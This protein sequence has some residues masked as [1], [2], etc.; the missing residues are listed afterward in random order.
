MG[1]VILLGP[2][3]L[4]SSVASVTSVGEEV[5]R[6]IFTWSDSPLGSLGP[7]LLLMLDAETWPSLAKEH[8]EAIVPT[9]SCRY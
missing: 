6:S 8:Q 2:L 1:T 5:W 4:G 9:F 3:L 7:K